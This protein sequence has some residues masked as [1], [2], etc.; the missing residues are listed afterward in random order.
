MIPLSWYLILA[1]GLFSI[2]LFGVR[3]QLLHFQLQLR[4]HFPGPLVADSGVLA[5]VGGD[6]RPIH[7]HAAQLGQPQLVRHL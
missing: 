6:F 2:G 4:D 7:A 5:G 3:D 1:A